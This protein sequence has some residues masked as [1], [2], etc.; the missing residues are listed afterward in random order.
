MQELNNGLNE[1]L[2]RVNPN[3]TLAH[4]D[5]K[6]LKGR[7]NYCADDSHKCLEL[8]KDYPHAFAHLKKCESLD[9]VL[10]SLNN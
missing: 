8:C 7:R 3:Q 10:V 9:K 6:L 4:E 5:L 2:R 1:A